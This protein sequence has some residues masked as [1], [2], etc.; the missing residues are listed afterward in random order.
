MEN[1]RL[2]EMLR[3]LFKAFISFFNP[4]LEKVSPCPSIPKTMHC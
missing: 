1:D 2:A 4:S 3:I